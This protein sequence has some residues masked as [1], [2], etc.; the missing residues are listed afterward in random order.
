MITI[1]EAILL[2]KNLP[3]V[4]TVVFIGIARVERTIIFVPN[5]CCLGRT[6]Q[7]NKAYGRRCTK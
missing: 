5:M 7:V 2:L 6:G 1:Y 4:G 3:K